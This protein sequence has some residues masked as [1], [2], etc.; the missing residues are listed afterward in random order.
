MRLASGVGC[1]LRLFGRFAKHSMVPAVAGFVWVN[2]ARVGAQAPDGDA[3]SKLAAANDLARQ[4][5][6]PFH[7][8]VAFQLYDV[9]GKPGE[10]GTAEEWWASPKC[11]RISIESPSLNAMR[12]SP[13]WGE[14]VVSCEALAGL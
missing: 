2:A 10:T 6:P 14:G 7:L 5:D 1:W 4:G 13:G 12:C 9:D 3:W 11:W 8:K